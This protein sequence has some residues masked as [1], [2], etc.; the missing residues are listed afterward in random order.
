MGQ[1]RCSPRGVVADTIS[2]TLELAQ[3]VGWLAAEQ[4][5]KDRK[6]GR[7]AAAR[8]HRPARDVLVQELLLRNTHHLGDVVMSAR[9]S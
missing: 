5:V 4:L 8:L 3:C 7:I 9:E 1:G 6:A 2:G